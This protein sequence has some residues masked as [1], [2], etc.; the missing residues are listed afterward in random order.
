VINVHTYAF[1]PAKAGISP[2]EFKLTE[3]LKK[4]SAW[5]DANAP[6]A[7]IW[8]TEFG[9]DTAQASPLHAPKIGDNSPE[10]VQAQWIV[11]S[12]IAIAEAGYDRGVLFMSRDAC[13]VKGGETCATQ[14][15]TS[16]VMSEKGSWIPKPSFYFIAAFRSRLAK[17]RFVKELDSGSPDVRIATFQDDAGKGAYVVWAPTSSAKVVSSYTLKGVTS[18]TLV[19]LADK[20]SKGAEKSFTGTMD[21]TETP[22]IVLVDHL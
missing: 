21:I 14:F 11:R 18:G 6:K 5:R 12:Y 17:M 2:E 16:G 3:Q 7:E 4:I 22:S 10:I 20:D 8:L 9:Y 15:G 19:T 13:T 1:G